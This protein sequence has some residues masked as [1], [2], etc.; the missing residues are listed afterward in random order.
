[1]SLF[2]SLGCKILF[3]HIFHLRTSW[4]YAYQ[5]FGPKILPNYPH[6]FFHHPYY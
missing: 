6:L 5:Q 3:F 4:A 1:M 2:N